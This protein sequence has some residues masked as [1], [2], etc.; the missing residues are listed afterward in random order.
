MSPKERIFRVLSLALVGVG[1]IAGV[2]GADKDGADHTVAAL[3]ELIHDIKKV[4]EVNKINS[5]E[6]ITTVVQQT[7]QSSSQLNPRA[8]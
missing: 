6:S 4:E 2:A 1:F 8:N 3:E 7:D 5:N